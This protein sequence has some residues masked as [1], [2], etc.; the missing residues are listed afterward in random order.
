AEDIQVRRK[1]VRRVKASRS[2]LVPSLS[3]ENLGIQFTFPE[4]LNLLALSVVINTR[5]SDQR[6][7]SGIDWHESALNQIPTLANFDN[8]PHLRTNACRIHSPASLQ[9]AT[10]LELKPPSSWYCRRQSSRESLRI[11]FIFYLV[12]VSI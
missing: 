6:R 11:S 9:S 2:N 10:H 3:R 8:L 4:H 1:S 5:E 12:R 7:I